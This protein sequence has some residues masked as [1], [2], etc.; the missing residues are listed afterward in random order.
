MEN[1]QE[2]NYS[3]V[4]RKPFTHFCFKPYPCSFSFAGFFCNFLLLSTM[5]QHHEVCI[6]KR[7]EIK[8]KSMQNYLM[9]KCLL[10]LLLLSS[11]FKPKAATAAAAAAFIARLAVK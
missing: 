6:K 9:E 5:Q 1:H 8:E 11:I 10:H 3:P 4:M 2:E 7:F